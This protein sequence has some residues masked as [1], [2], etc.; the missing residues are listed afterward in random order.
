MRPDPTRRLGPA[1]S[2]AFGVLLCLLL[3][4][5][6]SG[7]PTGLDPDDEAWVPLSRSCTPSS[8]AFSVPPD[9]S[10]PLPG[11]DEHWTIR[12]QFTAMADAAPGG[13]AGFYFAEGEQPV[14]AMVDPA[15][16]TDARSTLMTTA[17]EVGLGQLVTYLRDPE[18]RGARWD[19]RQLYDWFW[20]VRNPVF[21]LEGVHSMGISEAGNRIEFG[22]DEEEDIQRIGAV[23]DELDVPC[24][25]VAAEVRGRAILH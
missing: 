10:R 18:V 5:C 19:H 3:V 24:W 23:L 20:V 2:S 6:G 9:L 8:P 7:T 11:P 17:Q 21:S 14:V 15:R 12:E 4:G 22:V 16:W 13:F 1:E 25:L